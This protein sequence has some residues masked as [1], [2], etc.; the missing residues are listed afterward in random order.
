MTFEADMNGASTN[1]ISV[2]PPRPGQEADQVLEEVTS[3]D[4]NT[5]NI[6]VETQRLLQHADGWRGSGVRGQGSSRGT[7]LGSSAWSCS[8]DSSAGF[9]CSN[10][11]D[12]DH[13]VQPAPACARTRVHV[14]VLLDQ[15]QN[16]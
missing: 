2:A 11:S 1:H 7:F 16:V 15:D 10:I 4:T 5:G 8:T 6:Q 14:S 3:L 13:M 12:P 9:S